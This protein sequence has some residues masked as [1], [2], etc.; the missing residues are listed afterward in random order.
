MSLR[1]LLTPSIALGLFAQPL[2]AQAV[3]PRYQISCQTRSEFVGRLRSLVRDPDRVELGLAQLSIVAQPLAAAPGA[4]ADW[5][6]TVSRW[7]ADAE[8]PRTLRD[9]SCEAVAEAAALVVAVWIDE[10]AASRSEQLAAVSQPVQPARERKRWSGGLS[11]AADAALRIPF[12]LD[13]GASLSWWFRTPS[14][15]PII[16][17]MGLSI[18]PGSW[19]AP[20]Q[21]APTVRA[22]ALV[23]TFFQVSALLVRAG[24]VRAGPWTALHVAIAHGGA[25]DIDTL[26]LRVSLG[27]QLDW[28]LSARWSAFARAGITLRLFDALEGV[29][30]LGLRFAFT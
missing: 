2:A 13:A 25:D 7:H 10:L 19:D 17:D 6:L 26:G 28:T 23:E 20:K 3:S 22:H 21:G 27:A 15:V 16:L 8:P 12:A 11:L 14:A 29:G 9:A 18:W 5:A 4:D 1:C 24:D 30:G